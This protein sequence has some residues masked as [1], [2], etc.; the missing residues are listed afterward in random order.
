MVQTFTQSFWSKF[1]TH[2]DEASTSASARGRQAPCHACRRGLGARLSAQQG[3]TCPCHA[4][5]RGSGAR[6]SAQQGHTSPLRKERVGCAFERT[7]RTHLPTSQR[8]NTVAWYCSHDSVT[9]VSQ[10][11][12][13]C[14]VAFK[15]HD[16]RVQRSHST[17][18]GARKEEVVC[19]VLDPRAALFGICMRGVQEAA[20]CR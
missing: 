10:T 8:F 6:L 9:R 17:M 7:T 11:N 15:Q 3:H 5:R 19:A 2:V 20:L 4:C 1:E 18:Q 16:E 14:G 13:K 12:Q